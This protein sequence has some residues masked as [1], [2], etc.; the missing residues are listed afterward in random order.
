[1]RERT[2]PLIIRGP[3]IEIGSKRT[4]LVE[5]IDVAALSLAA[6]G[7]DIPDGMEGQDILASSH[8]PKEAVFGA[9]DRCGEAA[10]W[11]RSVRTDRYL[12]IKHFYPERPH[13]LPSQYKEGKFILKRLRE[14]HGAGSLSALS[15]KLLFSPTRAPEELFQYQDDVWQ[16][17]NLA[18]DPKYA[19]VLKTHRAHLDDWIERTGDPGPES[20]EVY[21]LET[22]HQMSVTGNVEVRES[23]RRHTELYKQWVREGK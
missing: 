1:M 9:R 20:P 19:E 6:A 18:E 7:I 23:Y 22:E 2:S 17:V 4:D 21:V 8:Q 13:L 15:E 11:V 14:L 3:G 10:D 5:H 16:I 12:Y